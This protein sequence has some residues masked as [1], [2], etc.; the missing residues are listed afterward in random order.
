[1]PLKAVKIGQVILFFNL[2]TFQKGQRRPFK[3]WLGPDK[4]SFINRVSE[5]NIVKG[6]VLKNAIK[7]FAH[8]DING[9][10]FVC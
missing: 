10:G 9:R 8:L 4:F 1:M 5:A 3:G 7:N 2:I 6:K